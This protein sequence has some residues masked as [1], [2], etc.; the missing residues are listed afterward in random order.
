MDDISS[1]H[2]ILPTCLKEKYTPQPTHQEVRTPDEIQLGFYSL[3]ISDYRII[4]SYM[5]NTAAL[6]ILVI[7][8]GES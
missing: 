7:T 5:V 2:D 6:S 3:K 8:H 1:I 4:L